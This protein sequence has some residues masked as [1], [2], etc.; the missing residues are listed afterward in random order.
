MQTRRKGKR[1]GIR[2]NYLTREEQVSK[3]CVE[4]T[5][6]NKKRRK[7]KGIRMIHWM[8]YGVEH[9]MFSCANV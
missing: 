6:G 8:W 9:E 4:D 3:N 1:K 7:K 5:S 2:R